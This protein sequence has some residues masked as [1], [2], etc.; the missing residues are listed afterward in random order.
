MKN[1]PAFFTSS[2][3][4]FSV[5]LAVILMLIIFPSCN[6]VAPDETKDSNLDQ[7][8]VALSV[9]QTL[10]AKEGGGANATIAAQQATIQAQ[11]ALATAQAQ[12]PPQPQPQQP[13][14]ECGRPTTAGHNRL[15]SQ[16]NHLSNSR[17][18][19]TSRNR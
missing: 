1:K 14:Q 5:C 12:Q 18:P 16:C 7:T 6:F 17:L 2:K 9:E 8:Q 3:R 19:G 10:T 13:T 4:I 15:S 11:A